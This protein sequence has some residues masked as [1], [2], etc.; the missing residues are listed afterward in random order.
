MNSKNFS[1]QFSFQFVFIMLLFLIIV[2]LSVM[3]IV[4]GKNIYANINEDRDSNYEIRVSLSYIANKIRQSDKQGTVEIRNYENNNAVVINETYDDENYETWIYF[5]DN[6]IYEMF[7]DENATFLPEE[8]M[9]IVDCDSLEITKIK[10]NL[11]KF[12]VS[13][14]A[15]SSELVLNLYSNN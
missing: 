7:A 2:I 13:S 1:K 3:I 10:D 9:K 4:L 8:G 6:A 11:Y 5:Y 15:D 14:S 12:A